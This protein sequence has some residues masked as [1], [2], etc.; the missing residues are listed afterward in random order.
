MLGHC[1]LTQLCCLFL[2]IPALACSDNRRVSI[3]GVWHPHYRHPPCKQKLGGC[4]A[5]SGGV[6]TPPRGGVDKSLLAN[7][8]NSKSPSRSCMINNPVRTE[9]EAPGWDLPR[10]RNYWASSAKMQTLRSCRKAA[11][12][13]YRSR[14][15]PLPHKHS[16][17]AQAR[18]PGLWPGPRSEANFVTPALTG[19]L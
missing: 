11:K 4:R 12:H 7:S 1:W 2:V 17:V 8:I 13:M 14:L 10:S 9:I 19:R 5:K 6:F 15:P 18:R 16:I 3:G